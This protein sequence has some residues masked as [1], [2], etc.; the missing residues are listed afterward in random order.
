[1]TTVSWYVA[2]LADGKT[3]LAEPAPH[4]LVTALCDGQQFR[5]LA[6]LR[7]A[8]YDEE[9]ICPAC[10]SDQNPRKN[11]RNEMDRTGRDR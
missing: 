4:G 3:H 7:G 11:R 2:S 1:M 10:R 6:A 8:P 9:Q 5:P